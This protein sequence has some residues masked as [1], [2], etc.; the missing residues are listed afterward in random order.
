MIFLAISLLTSRYETSTDSQKQARSKEESIERFLQDY[1]ASIRF[2]HSCYYIYCS[3]LG[4][5]QQRVYLGTKRGCFKAY[6][7]YCKR[8]TNRRKLV[9]KTPRIFH[10]L[11]RQAGV[12]VQKAYDSLVLF[13]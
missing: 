12:G 10:E 5:L 9:V 6:L 1:A 4:R 8:F 7:E 2:Y 11:R 3:S 13:S